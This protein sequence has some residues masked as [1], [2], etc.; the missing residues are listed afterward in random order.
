MAEPYSGV[1]S[2]K[3]RPSSPL[4]AAV[5]RLLAGAAPQQG[6]P[7]T[8]I[9]DEATVPERADFPAVRH[10]VIVESIPR[11][12]AGRTASILAKSRAFADRA[13]L[14]TDIVTTGYSGELGLIEQESAAR[15]ERHDLVRLHN[16]LDWVDR[17]SP[18]PSPRPEPV[19]DF[20]EPGIPNADGTTVSFLH[21]GRL[22]VRR[23]LDHDGSLLSREAFEEDGHLGI[24]EDFEPDV[25]LR[26]RCEFTRG[27][28]QPTDEYHYRR[29][30]SLYSHRTRR[31]HPDN[32]RRR[33]DR[34]DTYSPDGE[35]AVAFPTYA[36]FIRE[37]LAE[38][39]GGAETVLSV[40]ARVVG[41]WLLGWKPQR[42]HQLHVLHNTHLQEPYTEIG[43]IG[44]EFRGLLSRPATVAATV[45]LTN[46][47]RRDAEEHYGFSPNWL[48]IP[49]AAPEP[50]A[51]LGVSRDPDLVVMLTRLH[52][53]KRV[54][55][56]I[57]A[58][59]MVLSRRPSARLEIHGDGGQS[60]MLDDLITELGLRDSVSLEG[61]TTDPNRQFQRASLSLLTS[62]YEGLG[63]VISEAAANGCPTISYDVRYGP[64]DLITSGVDGVLVEAGDIAALAG[65]V[66]DLLD[67][68]RRRQEMSQAALRALKDRSESVFVRRWAALLRRVSL[69]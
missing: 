48:V 23:T 54:E 3:A 31:P 50:V 52:H 32:P 46:A 30:G 55:D 20:D 1:M 13:G 51:A 39:L 2:P 21:E 5:R 7:P 22:A 27:Q 38:A 10:V 61:Y 16:L 49:H 35:V 24:R 40:E 66:V 41:G 12:Y 58:W 69:T 44:L 42:I 34:I 57:R 29:D 63:L 53:Q 45:F 60:A 64:S 56:A 11:H 8:R 15:G 59:P 33:L 62:R 4:R 19:E 67:D 68:P 25:G 43:A 47:Q 28:K 6:S 14:A 65:A 37:S 26:H 36:A 17:S 18:P 9:L